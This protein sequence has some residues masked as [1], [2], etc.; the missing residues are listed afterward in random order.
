MMRITKLI[1]SQYAYL[2]LSSI[3]R[4]IICNSCILYRYREI[5]IHC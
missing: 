3:N 1:S 5:D 4:N 2:H